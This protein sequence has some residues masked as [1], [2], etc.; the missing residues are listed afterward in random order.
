M[1]PKVH[2]PNRT[3]IDMGNS[4]ILAPYAK[5][6]I[7]TV[8]GRFWEDIAIACTRNGYEVYTNCG[9]KAEKEIRGTK[10]LQ[11]SIDGIYY[12]A[13]RAKAFI[14]YR[15]GIC[16]WLALSEANMLVINDP[17]WGKEWN[18]NNFS[19]KE[20]KY[21]QYSRSAQEVILR[22]IINEIDAM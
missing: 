13:E 17:M 12:L 4:I 8:E 21:F 10:R 6:K 19:R 16:D 2:F 7:C 3:T 1:Y 9:S 18:L 14:S 5:S 22:E 11:V 20:V 15:S